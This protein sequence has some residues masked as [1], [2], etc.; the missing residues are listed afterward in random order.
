MQ[1][2][3]QLDP[4]PL[5]P[6][7]T[8]LLPALLLL[9][10]GFSLVLCVLLEPVSRLHIPSSVMQGNRSILPSLKILKNKIRVLKKELCLICP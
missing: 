4:Q 8:F 2:K 5:P 1:P 7:L 3:M 6:A 9:C 10:D